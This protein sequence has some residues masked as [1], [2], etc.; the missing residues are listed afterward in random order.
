MREVRERAHDGERA[1]DG[2]VVELRR[3]LAPHRGRVLTVRAAKADRGLPDALYACEHLAAVAHAHRVA[4]KATE[5]ARVL[6]QGKIVISRII[7]H[8]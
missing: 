3:E 6:A 8:S 7:W 5:D 1:R 2:E 4:E